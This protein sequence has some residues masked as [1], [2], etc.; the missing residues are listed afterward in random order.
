MTGIESKEADVAHIESEAPL[1]TLL[2]MLGG[3]GMVCYGESCSF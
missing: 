2:P 3:A 1:T